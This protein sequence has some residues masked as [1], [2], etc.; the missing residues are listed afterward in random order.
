MGALSRPAPPPD[1]PDELVV[2]VRFTCADGAE[3]DALIDLLLRERLAR[4]AITFA[5][6]SAYWWRGELEHAEEELVT[7]T[8]R[9]GCF[10]AIV[11]TICQHHSYE[12]PAVTMHVLRDAAPGVAE[13]IDDALG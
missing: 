10:G 8:T 6:P 7:L 9:A 12:L 11:A 3:A 1:T 2:E 13:W 5:S 4:A